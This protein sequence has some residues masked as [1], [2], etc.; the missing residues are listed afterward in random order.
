[1]WH[2]VRARGRTQANSDTGIDNKQTQSHKVSQSE[3]QQ[4]LRN[5]LGA[6]GGEETNIYQPTA[7]D[8]WHVKTGKETE[9]DKE[10]AADGFPGRRLGH[11]CRSRPQ[12]V[13]PP[14]TPQEK[15]RYGDPPLGSCLVKTT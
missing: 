4:G 10:K 9:K 5:R 2:R 3:E 14:P 11:L 6:E 15:R 12:N 7:G 8:I 1:M 13:A